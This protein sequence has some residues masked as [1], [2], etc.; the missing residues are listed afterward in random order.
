LKKFS[1]LISSRSATRFN[2]AA[3]SAFRTSLR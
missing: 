1:P 3:T 2:M